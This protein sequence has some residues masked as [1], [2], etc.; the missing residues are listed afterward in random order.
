MWWSHCETLIILHLFGP[1][2]AKTRSHAPSHAVQNC[3]PLT[4]S[5]WVKSCLKYHSGN[6][7][8]SYRFEASHCLGKLTPYQGLD[9]AVTFQWRADLIYKDQKDFA[10]LVPDHF[11][12]HIARGI[13]AV[14][15]SLCS[16]MDLNQC[17]GWDYPWTRSTWHRRRTHPAAYFWP[18]TRSC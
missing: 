2:L 7:S 8:S 10:A 6:W 14:A 3:Q 9:N 17:Y 5:D 15:F 4:D 18:L 1:L 12:R 16:R 11:R 13:S